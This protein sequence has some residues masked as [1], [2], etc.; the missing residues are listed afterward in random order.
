MKQLLVQKTAWHNVC[1]G[2]IAKGCQS[3]V[4]GQKLVVF[5]TGLCGQHC[6]YCPV[7]DQKMRM[8]KIYANERPIFSESELI[9]EAE[10]SGAMGAGITG[11]DPL[12]KVERC[13]EYTYLLKEH[14]GKK[15]H[16][17]LYTPLQL[18]TEER[19]RILYESGLDEIRFHPYLDNDEWWPRI[20]LARKFPWK[21]GVEIPALPGEEKNITKLIHYIKDKVDFLNLN[22]LEVSDNKAWQEAFLTRKIK[23]KDSQSYGVTG[24]QETAMNLI[25]LSAKLG[26]K[27]HFCTAKSK[28]AIQH[29]NRVK[30][31]GERM[32]KEYDLMDDEGMLTRGAIYLDLQPCMGY[33]SKIK[34]LPSE[35]KQAMLLK[36]SKL[37]QQLQKKYDIP[38]ELIEID[39]QKLRLL[40]GGWILQEIGS[41]LKN[42]CALVTEYPTWDHL[43]VQVEF[44]N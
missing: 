29:A 25:K 16:V 33:Y 13:A 15:F 30:R 9:Q 38:D 37:K 23:C 1:A 35:E 21:V 17:H 31:R 3:C 20:K 18:V 2:Q 40:T 6:W 32:K 26:L 5:V 36:L 11:G 42:K 19:L 24:S 27:T 43:E 34:A 12:T 4:K 39:P 22:E 10:E 28:D 44:L 8:D 14:F 7:S 41:E